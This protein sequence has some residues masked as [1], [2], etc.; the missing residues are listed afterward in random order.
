MRALI[1]HPADPRKSKYEQSFTAAFESAKVIVKLIAIG[2]PK[3]EMLMLRLHGIWASALASAV[4][5][6]NSREQTDAN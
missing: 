4:R 3:L 6:L 1:E 2:Y 5:L